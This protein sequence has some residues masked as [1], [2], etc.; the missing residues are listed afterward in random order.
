MVTYKER[1][2]HELLGSAA[3]KHYKAPG[4]KIDH[5]PLPNVASR[6]DLSSHYYLFCMCI[7][8]SISITYILLECTMPIGTRAR[9]GPMQHLQLSKMNNMNMPNRVS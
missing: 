5:H 4:M 9:I 1:E 2:H 6:T 7:F 3:Q 8:Q